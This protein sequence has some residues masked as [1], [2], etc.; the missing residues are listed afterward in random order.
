[1][2]DDSR[3]HFLELLKEF[4]NAMLVTRAQDGELRARPMAIADTERDGDL[5]FLT[6]ID[7]PKVD[8]IQADSNVNVSM[9]SKNRWLSISGRAEI[10]RDRALLAELWKE[11]YEVWF[12]EGQDDPNLVLLKVRATEGE[13]WD[14]QGGK[15]LKYVLDA[16]RAYLSGDTPNVDEEQSQK[17]NL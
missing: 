10:V 8:E 11:P 4:D 15:G 3:E 7:A 6:G 13:Y 16:T 17:V 14:M 12:P 1:M 9:Q 2:A 5:W